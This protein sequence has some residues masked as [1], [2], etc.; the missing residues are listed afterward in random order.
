[1]SSIQQT[2]T[3]LSN[4]IILRRCLTALCI[5]LGIVLPLL[6]VPFEVFRFRDESYQAFCCLEW[7]RAWPAMM[8]FYVGDKWMLLF[9]KTFIA[10][11]YLMTLCFISAVAIGCV[12]IRKKG[13]PALQTSVVFL[14]G[15]IGVVMSYLPI[16]SWDSGSYPTTAL[17]LLATLLYLD[18]PGRNTVIFMGGAAGL[19]ALFR[20]PMIAVLG[21]MYTCIIAVNYHK[22]EDGKSLLDILLLTFCFTVVFFI[23]TTIMLG[24]PAAYFRTISEANT[25]GGHTLADIPEMFRFSKDL[26][27]SQ[28]MFMLPSVVAILLSVCFTK[29][30]K[31]N[32]LIVTGAL[33]LLYYVVRA[34]IMNHKEWTIFWSHNGLIIP[35]AVVVILFSFLY[36]SLKNKETKPST[37]LGTIVLILFVL[38]QGFGSDAFSERFGWGLCMVFAFGVNSETM[39]KCRKFTNYLLLFTAIVVV[40]YYAS[41]LRRLE[42]GWDRPLNTKYTATI[43]GTRNYEPFKQFSKIDSAKFLLDNARKAGFGTGIIGNE[44]CSYTFILEE[45]SPNSSM[46]YI[47]SVKEIIGDI[48]RLRQTGNADLLF[49]MDQEKDSLVATTLCDAD[50]KCYIR[51]GDYIEIYAPEATIAKLPADPFAAWGYRS[52]DKSSEE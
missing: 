21:I 32:W 30:N 36:N 4:S 16:Y 15:T 9:G 44:C 40:G 45:T 19:M 11:R 48:E 10:L 50:Y 41:V 1:M 31:N 52:P 13:F 39:L 27:Y 7:E 38:L 8:T 23:G 5:V 33:L 51:I 12:Y 29:L 34:M 25:V 3:R 26:L 22:E 46:R 18:R 42:T 6:L 2:I 37:K 17:G 24:S 43:D 28:Y 14:I 20:I 47:P 49:W 35:T